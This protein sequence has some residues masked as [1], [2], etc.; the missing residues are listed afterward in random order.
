MEQN[1]REEVYRDHFEECVRHFSASIKARATSG[2]VEKWT[3][4]IADFCG[5]SQISVSAWLSEESGILP[6]GENEIRLKCFLD[7]QGYRIIEFERLTKVCRLVSEVIGYWVLSAQK[8][9]ELAGY[10]KLG[11]LYAVLREDPEYGLTKAKGQTLYGIWKERKD[12]LEQKK[13]EAHGT[14]C[15][16]VSNALPTASGVT[17]SPK[18]ARSSFAHR[19]EAMLALFD[20]L[21]KLLDEGLF[22]S[23]S[24]LAE[25]KEN[26]GQIVLKLSSQ[27][28]SLSSKLINKERKT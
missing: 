3:K 23:D 26:G 27:L 16:N 20:G 12:E 13:R 19:Q 22:E 25:L 2:S 6:A 9:A 5:V 7:M 17:A 11:Q 18:G 28:S 8:V 15:I 14:F 1:K 10:K 24:E 21:S 4:L